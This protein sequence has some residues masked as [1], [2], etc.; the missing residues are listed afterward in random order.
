VGGRAV[1]AKRGLP[2][3]AAVG[4]WSR[5]PCV[6]PVATG[7]GGGARAG[8]FVARPR[9][10]QTTVAGGFAA[11]DSTACAT[12]IE[13]ATAQVPRAAA[14]QHSSAGCGARL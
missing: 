12:G 10:C 11:D 14:V 13:P 4:R 7:G 9:P 2:C 8:R 5:R 3:G 6:A 1:P